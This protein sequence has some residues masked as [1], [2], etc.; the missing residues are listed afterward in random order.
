M[1]FKKDAAPQGDARVDLGRLLLQYLQR[2]AV[3]FVAV[4]AR[5]VEVEPIAAGLI[6]EVN[7][8]GEVLAIVELVLAQPVRGFDIALVGVS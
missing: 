1:V 3:A 2:R 8:T 4:A 5:D 7:A 6:E